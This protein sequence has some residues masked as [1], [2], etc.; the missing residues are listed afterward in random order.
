LPW[1]PTEAVIKDVG[2]FAISVAPGSGKKFSKTTHNIAMAREA[3]QMNFGAV[4]DANAVI[5][6]SM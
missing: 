6:L 1:R 5:E 4:Y 3:V 2:I